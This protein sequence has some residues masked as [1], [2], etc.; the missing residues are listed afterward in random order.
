MTARVT[1]FDRAPAYVA[2]RYSGVHTVRPLLVTI[3]AE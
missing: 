1:Y 3:S 2:P